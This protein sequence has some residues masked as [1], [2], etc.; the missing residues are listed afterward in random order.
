[1][2]DQDNLSCFKAHAMP[3]IAVHEQD[4]FVWVVLEGVSIFYDRLGKFILSW[5]VQHYDILM[6][7]V[8]SKKCFLPVQA[9]KDACWQ[10]TV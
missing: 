9:V 1:M 10:I 5:I 2:I 8:E 7:G 6:F 3:S 4:Q